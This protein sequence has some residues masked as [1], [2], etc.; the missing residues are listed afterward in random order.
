MHRIVPATPAHV[1][2]IYRQSHVLWGAGLTL[3][4][5]VGLW[6]DLSATAWAARHATFLVLEDRDGEVLSSLKLYRPR[7]AVDGRARDAAVI[8][9][10]FTPVERRGRGHASELIARVL[11]DETRRGTPFALLFSDIGGRL[12]GDLGF[13]ELPAEEQWGRLR[14]P[15]RVDDA[16]RVRPATGADA[17][18]IAAAHEAFCRRR[19]LAV[20]RDA[21]QW[22]FLRVRSGS[23][24]RRLGAG[25]LAPRHDVVERDGRFAGYIVAVAGRGEWTLREAGAVDGAAESIA[26]VLRAGGA[27]AWGAGLRRVYAWLP[28][29]VVPR[30]DEWRLSRRPRRRAVPMLR[31]LAAAL[32]VDALRTPEAAYLPF[33]DQF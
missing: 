28:P 7:I 4:D 16:W 3:D 2:R 10:V 19:R 18:A 20:L 22:E 25:D 8:G 9:A 26:A 14:L 23:F 17:G 32:D 33:Q 13:R 11:D 30:L 24:F 1:R 5:Y 31:P 21:E 15:R 27:W 6:D 29:D 12:Y